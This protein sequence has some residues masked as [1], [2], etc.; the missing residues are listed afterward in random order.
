MKL[1]K[2]EIG[3]ILT[4]LTL[5]FLGFIIKLPAVFRHHDREL[6][7]LFYLL[8]AIFFYMIFGKKR[9]SNHIIIFLL[10]LL[11]GIGIEVI[12]EL[13][14]HLSPKKIHGNFDPKDVFYNLLGLIVASFFWGIS[15]TVQK[16]I[17]NLNN[18]ENDNK[19]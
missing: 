7:F 16:V 2:P 14:N 10:L 3:L 18:T 13:S 6:H 1:T 12:Q 9:M 17:N 11:F 8:T 15:L 4:L 5:S 19:N